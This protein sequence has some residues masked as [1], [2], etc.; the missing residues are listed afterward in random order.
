[1]KAIQVTI[2]E[3]LLERLDNCQQVRSRGRS[4]VFREAVDAYLA[5]LEAEEIDRAYEVGYGA[6]P[7][8]EFDDWPAEAAWL[9]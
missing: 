2:D 8:E 7:P 4:A 6:A 1:M 3:G 9:G 5:K